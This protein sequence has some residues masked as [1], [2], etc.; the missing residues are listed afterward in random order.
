MTRII[1]GQ[2]RGRR[3]AVPASGTRPTS[4]RVRESMF[5]TL[6]SELLASDRSWD[7][8]LVLDLYAGSGALGLEA[9]SRGAGSVLLVE[10]ARSA[11]D[12][13]RRNI[14]AVGLAQ[15]QL[16]AADV[17]Q[18]SHRPPPHA[19]NLVFADPPYD[20]PAGTIATTL[21]ALQETG[22]IADGAQ[23]VVERPAQD[24]E[25]PFPVLWQEFSHRRYGDTC[26]WYGLATATTG[27]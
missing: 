10:K 27:D 18:I 15:V 24:P 21:A 17:L 9:A 25:S 7:Q 14:D 8:M 3:L 2:A 11:V 19:C 12:T 1:A 6:T 5:S 4:D 13:L 22:W 23:V 16:L 20:V 26:L